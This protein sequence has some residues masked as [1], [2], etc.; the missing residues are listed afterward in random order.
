MPPVLSFPAS[1]T[2]TVDLMVIGTLRKIS[3]RTAGKFSPSVICRAASPL[4][5]PGHA[6]DHASRSAHGCTQGRY[7]AQTDGEADLPARWHGLAIFLIR[8]FAGLPA[9]LAQHCF[10]DFCEGGLQPGHFGCGQLPGQAASGQIQRCG[11]DPEV[12][13]EP[14]PPARSPALHRAGP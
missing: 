10:S 12:P 8:L 6:C 5:H 7:Q 13:A 14:D 9:A 3:R 11:G 2:V 4:A 1:S